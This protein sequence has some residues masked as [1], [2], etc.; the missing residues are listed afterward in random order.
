MDYISQFEQSYP[1]WGWLMRNRN[2]HTPS[3]TRP[4][5]VQ[6]FA[7]WWDGDPGSLGRCP[8]EGA[9]PMDAFYDA[10]DAVRRFHGSSRQ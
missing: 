1:G 10:L 5:F 2:K 4:Y 6:L 7:P 9:S 3:L 8:G